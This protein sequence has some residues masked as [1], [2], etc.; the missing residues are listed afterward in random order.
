MLAS[1]A[2]IART[3]TVA[4]V[5]CVPLA[6]TARAA[7]TALLDSIV[8]RVERSLPTRAGASATSPS[9]VVGLS[10]GVD[11]AIAAWALKRCG[12]DVTAATTKNW[13]GLNEDANE[14][15][16]YRDDLRSATEIARKIGIPLTEIDFTR[17]YWNDV[18]EPYVKAFASGATPNPD[19]ECNRSVKFGALLRHVTDVMGGDL[20]ATGHY[21]RIDRGVGERV[22]LLRGVDETKDQSYFLASVSG[23]ALSKACF[24]LGEMLKS[25]TRE[26]ARAL[27]LP[28]AERRSSAGICFIGR[29]PF[30][31]FIG[32]YIVPREGAFVDAETSRPVPGAPP[33]KGLASYT[34]GQRAKIGGA[35][36]PWFVI[37]KNVEENVVYV[38]NGADH[39]ALFSTTA[40]LADEF[41]ISGERPEMNRLLAKARYA[42]PLT[43]VTIASASSESFTPSKFS[44]SYVS[45][46]SLSESL[47]ATFDAPERA[48]TPGQALVLYDG[49]VCLGGAVIHRVGATK[50]EKLYI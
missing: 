9:V 42:S 23:D 8:E 30:G 38:A 13:D 10:G 7:S 41:W 2:R 34:V 48:V 22:R 40:E 37:G 29:R 14:D 44:S 4:R 49:D 11:S 25:E 18:F 20:L 17:E 39:D 36:K 35:A 28:C 16:G 24:P 5:G 1:T 43:P 46:S 27:G 12:A 47:R 45:A 26:A 21:A 19:L 6:S 32:E 50:F 3:V 33:H 15:C 31:D